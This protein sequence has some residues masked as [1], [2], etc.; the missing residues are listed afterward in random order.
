MDRKGLIISLVAVALILGA[1]VF[2]VVR[3]YRRPEAGETVVRPATERFQALTAVPSDAMAVFCFD[4]SRAARKILADSTGIFGALVVPEAKAS[5]RRFLAVSGDYPV[6]VSLHNSGE[7]IPLIVLRLKHGDSLRTDR[8]IAGADSAGLKTLLLEEGSLLAASR[9][10]TLLGS[11]RRH[12]GDGLS[13]AM[14]RGFSEAV[15]GVSG[16]SVAVINNEYAQKLCQAR[17]NPAYRKYADWLRRFADWTAFAIST[18]GGF[19]LSGSAGAGDDAAYGV[20]VLRNG[21]SGEILGTRLLPSWT[22]EAYAVP[23]ADNEAWV[24]ARK[25][26][27]DSQGKL[28]RFNRPVEQF[29]KRY[30]PKEAV[31]GVFSDADTM[32]QVLLVRCGH[33]P[34]EPGKVLD[35]AW[36]GVPEVLFGELFGLPH[37]TACTGIGD[38]L[39]IGGR[40][41]VAAYADGTFPG[42]RTLQD[43]FS[44]AGVNAFSQKNT[45]FALY[46]SPE[47]EPG[48]VAA[49]FRKPLSERI[50]AAR[51]PSRSLP[52]TLTAVRGPRDV[53]FRFRARPVRVNRTSAAQS[54][55]AQRDTLVEVP[56]GPFSVR[57]SG[58][59]KTN[60]FYQNSALSLC[61]NDENGKGLWGVPFKQKLCGRVQE[62]DY[63]NNGKIQFLFCAGDKLYLMDRLGRFV[64]GF[65]VTLGKE[66]RLGP[67][68]YDFEGNHA[69]RAMVLHADNSL[70]LYDLHGRKAEGWQGITAP[71]TIK[72]LPEPVE[73]GGRKYWIVRTSLQTLVFGFNGGDPLTRGQGGKMLR[74]DT[75][76]KVSGKT[77][78]GTCYDGKVRDIKLETK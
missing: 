41:A 26:F 23:T 37:E 65:P 25:R 54:A 13:V 2:A 32:V 56:E 29:V 48:S 43:H 71:E 19:T 46:F 4:G 5:L 18:D 75:E 76:I 53:E 68:A 11:A 20:N 62:V 55:E 63:Y 74:P 67:D 3:L 8:L 77:L 40:S 15:S 1:I 12:V 6:C 78:S 47:E 30:A 31:K 16:G 69:Y 33:K 9:S 44:D 51:D 58:T 22:A 52:V 39:V 28:D 64:S 24:G 27:A 42:P 7:P 38:Y 70:E 14:S 36:A 57:N 50:D 66:V 72:N 34:S 45:A 59:G 17:L 21:P 61:L 35:N 49:I 60:T 73:A 10:E